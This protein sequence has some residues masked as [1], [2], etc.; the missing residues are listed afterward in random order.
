MP[1]IIVEIRVLLVV[2]EAAAKHIYYNNY[3]YCIFFAKIK[4]YTF[5][6]LGIQLLFASKAKGYR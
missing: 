1:E 4:T 3:I 2:I 6:K 5:F